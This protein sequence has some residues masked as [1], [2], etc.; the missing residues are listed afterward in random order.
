MKTIASHDIQTTTVQLSLDLSQLIAHLSSLDTEI[1]KQII[2]S[3]GAE[4]SE[5]QEI[6]LSDVLKE[7][8]SEKLSNKNPSKTLDQ[9]I[10]HLKNLLPKIQ[11]QYKIRS[12]GVF[13]SYVRGDQTVT[14]DLDLLVDFDPDSS[15]GLIKICELEN[16]LTQQLGIQVDLTLL[17]ELK[18]QASQQI[19]S[20]VVYL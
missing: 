6:S 2:R 12:L 8:L 10:H 13:G 16:H 11:D 5:R 20:E 14:S 18:S 3:L 4:L 17:N 19:L 7:I 1:L 15:I 9:L